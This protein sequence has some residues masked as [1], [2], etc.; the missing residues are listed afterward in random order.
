MT[1]S[2]D[3]QL[4]IRLLAAAKT[5]FLSNGYAGANVGRIASAAGISK[6]T[7]YKYVASKQALLFEV[8]ADVLSGPAQR[9]AQASPE[10]SLASRLELYLEGFSTLAFSEQG[11]ASYRLLMSEGARF[12]ELAEAY[13]NSLDQYALQP[14]AREL[15]QAARM[16]HI[17][18]QDYRLAT[19]MLFSMVAAETLRDAAIGL[20]EVPG[21]AQRKALVGQA[22]SIFLHGI[23]GPARG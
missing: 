1:S 15:E 20:G 12:P 16:G 8:M 2:S 23:S 11:L 9:M 3:E 10:Q 14:V 4:K 21:E 13:V 19:R 7:V 17:V 22:L 5:E 18:Q 6:K